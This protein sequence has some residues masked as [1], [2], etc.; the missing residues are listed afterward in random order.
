MCQIMV[1]TDPSDYTIVAA[2]S[3]LSDGQLH[4]IAFHSRKMAK[5]EI[6]YDLDDMELL[7]IVVA[8][9]QWRRYLKGAHHQIQIYT[10]HYSLE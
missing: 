7:A 4:H 10:D 3:Q 1:K 8:L 5:A 6:N 2:H 9:K